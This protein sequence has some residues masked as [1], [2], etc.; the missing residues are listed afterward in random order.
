MCNWVNLREDIGDTPLEL[1]ACASK[2]DA[3]GC[4]SMERICVCA[5]YLCDD[6]YMAKISNRL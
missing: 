2:R 4:T 3:N 6:P 1:L 5:E